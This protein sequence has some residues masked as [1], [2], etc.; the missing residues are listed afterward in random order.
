LISLR[1]LRQHFLEV[2]R[3]PIVRRDCVSLAGFARDGGCVV[4]KT[5]ADW[6]SDNP[7]IYKCVLL[8]LDLLA[9][10]GCHYNERLLHFEDIDLIVQAQSKGFKTLKCMRFS[11]FSCHIRTGG[12][13]R[14]RLKR[15]A[16]M[17]LDA[18]L[19]KNSGPLSSQPARI[20]KVFA[21][22]RL[23]EAASRTAASK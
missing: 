12:C 6:L 17:S 7:S 13:E 18:L 11:Y 15:Q 2:Q 5:R 9:R 19:G 22:A 1:P 16:G 14:S 4:T 10:E 23:R 20:Q 21:W 3:L 8:N